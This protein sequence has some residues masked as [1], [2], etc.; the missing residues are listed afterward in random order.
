MQKL[1]SAMSESGVVKISGLVEPL[2]PAVVD[3]I[4][5]QLKSRAVIVVPEKLFDSTAANCKTVFGENALPFLSW[6]ILPY[7]HKY[8]NEELVAQRIFSLW[9]FINTENS[10]LITTPQALMW[11]TLPAD[12]I[13]KY[14][15]TIDRN[16]NISQDKLLKKLADAGYRRERIVEFLRSFARRGEIIDFFSPAH[17][18]PVRIEYFGDN[19]EE[20]RTFSTRD[21]RSITKIKQAKILPAVEWLTMEEP[22]VDELLAHISEDAKKILPKRELEELTARIALDRHFPGEIWFSPLFEPSTISPLDLLKEYS[23]IVIAVEP[24]KIVDE[25]QEFL[26]RANDLYERVSWED[27]SPLPPEYIFP[28]INRFEKIFEQGRGIARNSQFEKVIQIRE[29]PVGEDAIDFESKRVILKSEPSEL[30]KQIEF[31]AQRGSIFVAI[32]SSRQRERIEKYFGGKIPVPVRPGAVSTSFSLKQADTVVISGDDILGFSRTM[33]VSQRYHQGRAM[34]AHYGLEQGDFVVHSDYGIAKFLGIKQLE[35][36]GRTTELLQLQ[37]S[38]DEKLYVPMED[39]YL[40]SPYLGPR[41]A[42]RLSKL[43]G[44]KWSSIKGRARKKVFELAGELV[45]IYAMRQIKKRPPMHRA[46]EWE[47]ELQKTFP[48]DETPDQKKAIKDV[49][50]DLE[51]EYPMDRLLCGDV[52]FGKTEV[53]L[54][55]AVRAVSQGYQVA[56]LVPT[57]IL[58][59]Q[60]YATF[61]ERLQNMPIRIEMLCRFTPKKKVSQIA[62]DIEADKIDIAIGTHMLL[63]DK[64][65]FRKLG[66]LIVDEEQWFGVKHKEKLKSLRAEVDVLTMTATPI[67]RTLYFSISGLRDL[68][69]IETPPVSQRPVFTQIVPWNIELFKKAIYQEIERGGQIFFVHNRVET[70]GGIEAVLKAE[71]PDLKIAVAHGQMPERKLERT[72]LDFRDGK[73]DMLLSTTIIESGTDISNVNTII[74]NRADKFGLSQLYQLRGRVGRADVQAYAYLVIPPY[75]SMTPTARKRLRAI[76]EHTELGSGYHLAM[77]D[78]EIRG[79]G[80]LLGKEQSGFVDEIGLDLYTKML[81]EAVAEL[82]GQKPP[83][84][85]PI[86]FKI[87]FDAYL[88]YDYIPE[89]ENRLWAYQRLFTADKEEKI[90]RIKEE[91]QDRFG[92][93]PDTAKNLVDFLTVRIL[94]TQIGFKYVS[95][96]K[97]WITLSFDT[98]KLSLAKLDEKLSKYSPTPNLVLKPTPKLQIPRTNDIDHDIEIILRMFQ[99]FTKPS[100]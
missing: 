3:A 44:K 68:S 79:A 75:R 77:E 90:A 63:S 32:S 27:F 19:I 20:I 85:E 78:M 15:L 98:E 82:R 42:A 47:I 73:Y 57:T 25:A 67:P 23:P 89:T 12:F 46:D 21:Q 53:A 29:I 38:S 14:S 61:R 5:R 28:N 69:V 18:D 30:L 83:M 39:F 16:E 70:I 2:Y 7:A 96:G 52:G 66:L 36:D 81:A 13:E 100:A 59:E 10:I 37:F 93:L 60:H 24:E 45:R 88:P 71:M 65:H 40:V 94:A 1:I 97:K 84:F 95:F 9:Q 74:I 49:S 43:G 17:S 48:F 99:R 22:S 4:T 56:L 91:L 87:D 31:F 64:I 58:A 92:R 76:M 50:A 33:F 86:P 34:L 55:A 8:P 54:R 11:R 72:V 62:Q 80:N 41:S 26:N 6:D 35:I 51:K